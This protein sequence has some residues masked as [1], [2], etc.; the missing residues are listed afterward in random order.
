M[1][2]ELPRGWA[3]VPLREIGEAR[4]GETILAKQLTPTG[5]PVYSAGQANEPWGLLDH[6]KKLL[7]RS[8]VV[9][10]AR[11]SIGFPKIPKADRF[12]CTQTTISVTFPNEQLANF[13][14]H[15]LK[16]VDWG[17]L[18]KGG[19]IPMLTVVAQTLSPVRPHCRLLWPPLC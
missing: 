13:V 3:D 16:S 1:I 18:T 8:T 12:A 2:A 10:S 6:P 15:W 7:A 11:G 19:A 14:C 5:F 4:M 9:I 17:A